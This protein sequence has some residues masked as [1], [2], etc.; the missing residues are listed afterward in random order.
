M[1]DRLEEIVRALDWPGLTQSLWERGYA[2]TPPLL[3]GEQCRELIALYN[4]WP[5]FRSHIVMARYRFGQGDYKYFDYPLPP[6]VETLREASYP[7]LAAVA[8]Q[9]SEA[10]GSA[11]RYPARHADF[12]ARCRKVGQVR[13]TPL[14][15]HYEAG[16]YN[17]LHQDLYGEVAFPLQMACFLSRPGEDYEGGEFVLVEQQPRAQSKPEVLVPRQGEAVIFTTRYRPVKGARGYYRT[18]LKHGVSRV[19]LGTRYT[20]GIIYHDAE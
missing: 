4:T 19:R 12:I 3:E 8:N 1:P 13:A 7:P 11:E 16:D 20:L 18:N 14:L 5:R 2:L 10:T 9:W 15:L 6:L 17:G